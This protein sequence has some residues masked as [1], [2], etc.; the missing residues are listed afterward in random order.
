MKRLHFDN[1]TIASVSTLVRYHYVTPVD[2]SSVVKHLLS[3]LG[4]KTLTKLF[5]VMKGDSRAKQ[6]FCLE[7]VPVVDAMKI[8]MYEIINN[9]ECYSQADLAVDGNDVAAA[10]FSGKEIGKA[11]E[12]LLMMVMDNQVENSK[13]AL[14]KVM[15]DPTFTAEITLKTNNII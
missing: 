11:L 4:E 2:D 8:R 10:G 14:E 13:P 3:K 12:K 9:N 7:R 5:E 1:A 6:S 15:S